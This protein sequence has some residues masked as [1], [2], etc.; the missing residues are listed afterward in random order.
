[1]AYTLDSQLHHCHFAPIQPHFHCVFLRLFYSN[2]LSDHKQT[3]QEKKTLHFPTMRVKYRENL[4]PMALRS[5]LTRAMKG[6]RKGLG[7]WIWGG[8][9]GLEG[10]CVGWGVDGGDLGAF[11]RGVHMRR[12]FSTA[13][14]FPAS[15]VD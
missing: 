5:R 14:Q 11:S 1:M 13:H 3:G 2:T 15:A 12:Q 8:Y 7:G 4:K 6:G 9:G 10:G